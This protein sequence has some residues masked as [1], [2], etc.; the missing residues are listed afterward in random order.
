MGI[1]RKGVISAVL[2]DF[3]ALGWFA[4][5]AASA[6]AAMRLLELRRV[7]FSTETT[8][9]L[10]PLGRPR[11]EPYVRGAEIPD[12]LLE[13]RIRSLLWR[14]VSDPRSIDVK[15]S[16]GCVELKGPILR[17]EI[18]PLL[19]VVNRVR[20]VKKVINGLQV[21]AEYAPDA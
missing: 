17:H 18:G 7:P 8:N 14:P 3:R 1:M 15:V 10:V 20:G 21:R 4:L 9:A 13:E 5:G 12:S 11:S 6:V 2:D 16:D 19:L